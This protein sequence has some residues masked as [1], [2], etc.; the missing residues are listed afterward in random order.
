MW[1]FLG[2]FHFKKPTHEDGPIELAK[3][4]SCVG[5]VAES[6]KRSALRLL[7]VSGHWNMNFI[8]WAD[9]GR[10]EVLHV[11]WGSDKRDI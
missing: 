2:R 5:L 10:C 11:F 8:H 3:S 4:A 1:V 6:E 9:P 7:C